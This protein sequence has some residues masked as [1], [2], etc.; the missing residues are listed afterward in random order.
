MRVLFVFMGLFCAV[1]GFAQ[2]AISSSSPVN[3]EA[4]Y[5]EAVFKEATRV[6]TVYDTVYV[7]VDDGIPWNHEYFDHDR[8]LRREFFDPAL[9]VAYS[10]S[11]SFISGPLGSISQT[12]YLMHLAYEFTPQLNLYADLGLWMPLYSTLRTPGGFEREDIRQGNVDFV[13]P[14]LEL[15]YRPTPNTSLHLM[16]VNENDM[17]KTYGPSRHP[18]RSYYDRRYSTFYR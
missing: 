18:Y 17:I 15:V 13:M 2:M 6:D 10:Y 14:D 3:R 8:L 5:S 4:P 12:S 16:L 11:V 1:G 7:A 9:S